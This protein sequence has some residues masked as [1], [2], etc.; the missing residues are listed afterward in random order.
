M[1][2]VY[3]PRHPERTVLYRVFFHHYEHFLG[4]YES[5]FEKEYGFFR[6]VITEVVERRDYLEFIA[7]VTSHIPD[8][9][10]VTVRYFGLYANAHRGKVRKASLGPFP[11]RIV[12]EEIRP[13]PAKGWAEMIRKVYEV[14]PT[15]SDDLIRH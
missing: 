10:Q 9:G 1:A 13:I 12:E 5:R 8:K 11:L 4:E 7:R 14:N 3:R 15:Q 6:P 2:G